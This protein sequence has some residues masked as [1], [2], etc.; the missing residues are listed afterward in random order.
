MK[1]KKTAAFLLSL[2]LCLTLI[3]FMVPVQASVSV[4]AIDCSEPTTSYANLTDGNKASSWGMDWQNGSTSAHIIIKASEALVASCYAITTGED[5]KSYRNRNPRDWKLYGCND[6]DET[7]KAGGTWVLLHSVANDTVLT[8]S[9]SSTY[10]YDLDNDAAYRYYMLEITANRGDSY[11]KISEFELYD[12]ETAP[13]YFRAVDGTAGNNGENYTN[14]FDGKQTRSHFT[15]YCVPFT[16]DGVYITTKASEPIVVT[17]YTLTTGNDTATNT[18]RNPKSWVLYGCNDY[19]ADTKTGT[20]TKVHSVTDD[21]AMQNT[22][23]ASF[24]FTVDNQTDYQYYQFEIT[25]NQ[26]ADVMQLCGISFSYMLPGET[27]FQAVAGKEANNRNENYTNLFDGKKTSGDFTKYCTESK[28]ADIYVIAKSYRPI[29][30]TGYTFTTGNDTASYP[31]RNPKSWV[32]YGC[33]DYNADT[34]TGSWTEI[35][36]VTNDT[37]MGNVNFTPYTFTFD[38]KQQFS[39]YRFNFTESQGADVIQL[40]EIEFVYTADIHDWQET[41]RKEPGCTEAGYRKLV[42]GDCGEEQTATLPALGHKWEETSKDEPTCIEVGHSHQTCSVCGATR[43]IEIS[44]ID[45]DW[46]ATGRTE[47]TCTAVGY[48]H[49]AC[50]VCSANNDVELPM[51]DHNWQETERIEPTC[52]EVGHSHQTCTGCGQIKDVELPCTDHT[53]EETVRTEPTCFE[54]GSFTERC[55]ACGL[56]RETA[57][58]PLGHIAGN[59]GLC[60]RCGEH[61]IRIDNTYYF[62]LQEAVNSVRNGQTVEILQNIALF[63]E[64]SVLNSCT[65]DLNGFTVKQTADARLIKLNN[66]ITLTLKDS[67]EAK[68]GTL[69][70][71]KAVGVGI[72]AI[73]GG[74]YVCN[75]ATLNMVGGTISDCTANSY[76]GGIYVDDSGTLN[77]SDGAVIRNCAALKLHGGGIINYGT[78]EIRDSKIINCSSKSGGGGIYADGLKV[79]G[80]VDLYNT[81]VEGCSVEMN[82]GGAIGVKSTAVTVNENSIIRKN[83]AAGNYGAGICATDGSSVTVNNSKITENTANEGAG[84]LANLN[85]SVVLNGS[86]VTGNIA[87]AS[88]GGVQLSSATLTI[89]D[90]LISNNTANGNG[91]GIYA[92]NRSS[93]SFGGG[94]IDGN[95]AQWGGGVYLHY[96]SNM[97][98]T[99]GGSITS[100]TA[101]HNGGGVMLNDAEKGTNPT[102]TL[103]DGTVAF[104]EA[105]GVNADGS[106]N[107]NGNGGGICGQKKATVILSGGT[108]EYNTAVNGGGIHLLNN[109]SADIRG[110]YISGNTAKAGSGGG[111]YV[112]SQSSATLSGGT[113]AQNTASVS[114]GGIYANGT[115]TVGGAPRVQGNFLFSENETEAVESDN[116]LYLPSGK[117]VTIAQDGLHEVDAGHGYMIYPL[118]YVTLQNGTADVTQAFDTDCSQYFLADNADYAAAYENGVVKLVNG[119]KVT[120]VFGNDEE[121][122]TTV[123]SGKPVAVPDGEPWQ[124][125]S[126]FVGWLLNGEYYDFSQP[127]TEEITL[128]P[129]WMADDATAVSINY[130]TFYAVGLNQNAVIYLAAYGD[131]GEILDAWLSVL[132][133]ETTPVPYSRIIADT[134][135]DTANASEIR[136]F[137]WNEKQ[138]PLC[139]S[140]GI[141]TK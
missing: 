37:V 82:G 26:G 46:Q 21:T 129:K 140:A 91:G 89:T 54:S 127:I 24:N 25:E 101:T 6:Y 125:G 134:G 92:T 48:I 85:S 119:I 81:V 45:H 108:V 40:C 36:S 98:V 3:P 136:V 133:K 53:W 11:L 94:F 17:G 115:L 38:N 22:N 83:T 80:T 4:T 63:G 33:N 8:D 49:Q 68:T 14:L 122:V 35:H 29:A 88:G 126:V 39:Y 117:T 84:I 28:D 71:G 30:V 141:L 130:D 20:W 132:D 109:S 110:G 69:C 114:G 135:L 100:N 99:A 121:R 61:I 13:I 66:G 86:E 78:A 103:T 44:L 95:R 42:C 105:L 9:N 93:I 18:G 52:T 111:I 67:S 74:V 2:A 113:V 97:T 75:F 137:L 118:L 1:M 70:G 27:S 7:Y 57:L 19:N 62:D 10:F 139:A 32:L 128:T 76:G 106:S 87:N 131:N 138:Q 43:D 12:S 51:I 41:E 60:G 79:G 72:D 58:S 96:G 112:N 15:K 50:S 73:G 23:F 123:V 56:E 120:F 55:A 64:I 124:V 5:S 116:N 47:P 104:N 107:A 102:L 90:S 65:V 31:G 59:D 16:S 34:K 77:M